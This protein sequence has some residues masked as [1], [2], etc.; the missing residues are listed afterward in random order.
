[1]SAPTDRGESGSGRGEDGSGPGENGSG[2]DEARAGPAGSARAGRGSAAARGR[3][4]GL[5]LAAGL[6]SRMEGDFKLLLPY[7]EGTVVR[8]A[9]SAARAAGLDPVIA[10]VGHRADEMR[11]ALEGSGARTVENPAFREGMGSSLATG[12]RALRDEPR[13]VGAAILLGDEPGI[14]PDAIRT[15]VEAWRE[16][17]APALRTHYR[18]RPG[19]PVLFHRSAF[20]LLRRLRGDRGPTELISGGRAEVARLE[21]DLPAPVDVDTR[22]DYEAAVRPGPR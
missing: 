9:V 20:P 1:M 19:H 21:L 4:A 2:R 14:R 17:G 12:V 5:V 22:A 13:V 6:S 16:S 15:A 10:V 3:V 7:G 11:Q 18:D 8:A